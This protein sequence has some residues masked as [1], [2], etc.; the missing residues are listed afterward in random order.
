MDKLYSQSNQSTELQVQG[1][2]QLNIDENKL[3]YPDFYNLQDTDKSLDF[4]IYF[5]TVLNALRDYAQLTDLQDAIHT[6]ND[7]SIPQEDRNK[8]YFA[9][10]KQVQEN[11]LTQIYEEICLV[12]P[13]WKDLTEID[14]N[15]VCVHTMNVLYLTVNDDR[16][17]NLSSQEQN[18]M[19][20]AVLLHDV[21]KLGPPHFFG[22]DHTH[23]FK[24][25]K[26]VL[27]AF[28]RLGLI[29][30]DQ[31]ENLKSMISLIDQSKEKLDPKLLEKQRDT[32][33]T[34]A[35]GA[36]LCDEMHSHKYLSDI[37][38]LFWETIAER[39]SFIDL[40]FRLVFFHQSLIG[41][42]DIP[43]VVELSQEERLIYCDEY[44]LTIMKILMVN[45]SLS[46]MYV[47]DFDQKKCKCLQNF[48]DNSALMIEDYKKRKAL[49]K[50]HIQK[51]L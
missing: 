16:F 49:L 15:I 9:W 32:V 17:K 41:I 2:N 26:A 51:G 1:L 8:R 50:Y 25:G 38:L 46:Y 35:F 20:W 31:Q 4:D 12:I 18:I 28:N 14:N 5:P 48:D 27:E 29:A 44:F 6:C 19:K 43:A 39:G 33:T 13:E 40:V 22:K 10:Y 30:D 47:C 23:P 36:I 3:K 21:R 34:P 24:G 42:N 11:V 7:L 45:D 37:F